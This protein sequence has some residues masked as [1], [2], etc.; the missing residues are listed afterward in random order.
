[1]IQKSQI[2]NGFNRGALT[3]NQAAFLQHKVAE[4]LATCFLPENA[5]KI[6]EIGCGTGLLSQHLINKFPYA[7]LYLTDIATSMLEQCKQQFADK[8]N[9]TFLQMDAETPPNL[10][11]FDLI[12]SSMTF[13]WFNQL[14]QSIK[15]F[16]QQLKPG[17]KLLFS[18]LS[19]NSLQ[20]W[21]DCCSENQ[22]AAAT[23]LFPSVNDLK[24]EFPEIKFHVELITEMYPSAHAFLHTLK[25]IGAVA[26]REN[27]QQ[28]TAG[29]LRK[30]LRQRQHEFNISYEVVY[31]EYQAA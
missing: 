10:P 4:K 29:A 5:G 6:L 30:L 20:E 15:H 1:M 2:I 12:T 27:Y 21:R 19:D 17:G 13:H 11:Q 14:T 18:M 16:K 23:P 24:Q 8:T 25:S 28:L 7:D 3:Y 31:A 9:V 26:P 22:I